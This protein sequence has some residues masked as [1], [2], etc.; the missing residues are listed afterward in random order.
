[1]PNICLVPYWEQY[2]ND[3]L[4]TFRKPLTSWSVPRPELNML[5]STATKIVLKAMGHVFE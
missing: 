2:S 4:F 1:M 5:A 3:V